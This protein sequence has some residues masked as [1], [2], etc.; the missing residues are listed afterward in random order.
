VTTSDSGN[1]GGGGY[2]EEQCIDAF[3]AALD[4]GCSEQGSDAAC[5]AAL[6]ALGTECQSLIAALMAADL[7]YADTLEAL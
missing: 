3:N 1:G 6:G 5:C 7:E 2:S 4:G